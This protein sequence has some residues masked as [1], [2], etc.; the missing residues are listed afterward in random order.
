MDDETAV[1]VKQWE[2]LGA[3]P[4]ILRNLMIFRKNPVAKI[5]GAA[6]RDECA[7]REP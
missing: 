5:P 2:N 1:T 7:G 4:Y 6:L 3:P